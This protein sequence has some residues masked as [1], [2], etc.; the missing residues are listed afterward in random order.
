MEKLIKISSMGRHRIGRYKLC[1]TLYVCIAVFCI[2]YIPWFYNVFSVYGSAGLA[3]PAFS[4]WKMPQFQNIS[5]DITIGMLVA[6]YYG[7]HFLYLYAAGLLAGCV[8][9]KVGSPLLASLAAFG[10]TAIPVL[11]WGR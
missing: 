1:N 5:S 6:A 2:V 10:I 11:I 3:A 7:A 4:L 8:A 9:K